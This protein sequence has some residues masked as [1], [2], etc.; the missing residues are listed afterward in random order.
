[1]DR[2]ACG[3]R[4]V[5]ALLAVSALALVSVAA[6]AAAPARAA[7]ARTAAKTVLVKFRSQ[8]GTA[9]ADKA[10][11][12]AGLI[13][14]RTISGIDTVVARAASPLAARRAVATL[15]SVQSVSY[16]EQDSLAHAVLTPNDPFYSFNG[17]VSGLWPYTLTHLDSAWDYA[18]GSPAVTVAVLDTGVD[19]S[20]PDLSGSVLTGYNAFNGG[21]NTADDFGHGTEVASVVAAHTNNGIGAAGVCDGCT[22]YPVKVLDANG[23]GPWDVVAAGVTNAANS[24]VRVINLSLAGTFGSLTL[25]SAISYAES[26]GIIVVAAAGN[27]YS[28]DP[29]TCNVQCGG[30][31]AAYPGVL[32]VAASDYYDNLYAFSNHG[33]WVQVA[34]PGCAQV[35]V[36][37]RDSSGALVRDG[38]GMPIPNG[39]GGECGTSMASPFTA[40]LAALAL[41]GDSLASGA[42][43]QAA[44]ESSATLTGVDTVHGRVDAL[45]LFHTLGIA[46]AP[47]NLTLPSLIG[48]ARDGETLSGSTGS[49]SG[50]ALQFSRQ[51]QRAGGDGVWTAIAGATDATYTLSAADVGDTVRLS[52]TATNPLGSSSAV[53]AASV[54]VSAAPATITGAVALSGVE[55]DASILTATA[56]VG[57]TAP[58]GVSYLWQR[59]GVTWTTISGAS[60]PSYMLS[61][62]DVGKT[63]KVT[64]SVSNSGG[65]DSGSAT[66]GT[67]AAAPP[68][69]PSS[70][71]LSG[72]AREGHTLT[73]SSSAFGGTAPFSYEYLWE[74]SAGG[75]WTTIAGQSG[76]SYVLAAADVA[77]QVRVTLT[78]TNPAGAASVQ[79]AT[80]TVEQAAP[81]SA[82]TPELTGSAQVGQALTVST[83][84]W[85]GDAATSTS[86]RWQ[87]S[88]DGVIW[89]TIAGATAST[90]TLIAADQGLQVRASVTARNAS[91]SASAESAASGVVTAIPPVVQPPVVQ[92]PVA[93]PSG[94]G[95]G[96]GG[97]GSAPNMGVALTNL[98]APLLGQEMIYDL[99]VFGELGWGASWSTLAHATFP[100]QVTITRV[101]TPHGSCTFSGQAVDCDLI[102]LNPG[103]S[104]I[105][106][107]WTTVTA[108]GTLVA[109]AS[110][111]AQGEEKSS[112]ADNTTSLSLTVAD[113]NAPKPTAPKPTVPAPKTTPAGS[114]QPTISGSPTVGAV[115]RALVQPRLSSTGRVSYRW[116]ALVTVK[117]VPSWQ[118]VKG[119]SHATLKLS[120]GLT[121]EKLRV[122]VTIGGKSYTS[123][124]TAPVRKR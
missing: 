103:D 49:F 19:P 100:D 13:R 26:K 37:Q 111:S 45:A 79:A 5:G 110:V 43:I 76:A 18:S 124:P 97:G 34:A 120:G 29:N 38:S 90:Y 70:V 42:Q 16:A 9:A 21:T 66:S 30:Y 51:W 27:A 122:T 75:T 39:Y 48:T 59:F 91:G 8:V 52:V 61:S 3:F 77:G 83:G 109:T 113:P 44:I 112:Q 72:V 15:R 68:A 62:A 17:L 1:M 36:F 25:Q 4:L 54:T 81:L 10:L 28:N 94:G 74:R 88:A 32:S 57:G 41:S 89:T 84:I 63:V 55:R 71:T 106:H 73:V 2:R 99:R 64:V 117:G 11:A 123:K 20:Q 60:G 98:S 35:P 114:L 46:N 50:G 80:G 96:G 86:Y 7:Q 102:W 116:Q 12:R 115:L 31:P 33:T 104:V 14:L 47:T 56:T 119:A 40:G 92:P 22:I 67:I 101:Y 118:T 65:S 23:S 121:G 107:I 85:S 58:V 69:A 82:T 108:P 93:P 105:V 24:G 87:R 6:V 95:G 53:S 78:A